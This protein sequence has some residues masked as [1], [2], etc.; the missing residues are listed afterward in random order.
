M[1][2]LWPDSYQLRNVLIPEL[3]E[4]DNLGE[5]VAISTMRIQV[6]TC[7]SMHADDKECKRQSTLLS[8]SW[9]GNMG[10]CV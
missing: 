2:R 7:L 4:H 10:A 5:F 3:H 9:K 1:V 6:P 8:E